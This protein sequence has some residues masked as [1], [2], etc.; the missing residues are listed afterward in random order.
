M[1]AVPAVGPNGDVYA[2][3]A[4]PKGLAFVKSTDGGWTFGKEKI[5]T[6]TPVRWDFDVKGIF[7]CNGLPSIGVDLSNGKDR[8]TIHVNWAD[9]RNGDPDILVLISSDGGETWTE[10]LA[11]QRRPQGQR[12][13]A[14][15]HLDG[16]RSGGRL[17]EHRLIRPRRAQGNAN[18]LDVGS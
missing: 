4:G 5:L 16:R 7:R 18:G 1:G 12:Q 8:G 10:A 13:G 3:W 11:R 15:L 9:L 2:V 17:G 14:I 6:D